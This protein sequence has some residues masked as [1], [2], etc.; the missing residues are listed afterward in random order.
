MPVVHLKSS[1]QRECGERAFLEFYKEPELPRSARM[2]TRSFTD[3]EYEQLCAEYNKQLQRLPFTGH[4]GPNVLCTEGD[5]QKLTLELVATYADHANTYKIMQQMLAKYCA[6]GRDVYVRAKPPGKVGF[7][8]IDLVPTG[9]VLITRGGGTYVVR[10]SLPEVKVKDALQGVQMPTG[11]AYMHT[12][13]STPGAVSTIQGKAPKKKQVLVSFGDE[14]EGQGVVEGAK[15]LLMVFQLATDEEYLPLLDSFSS[16]K[17]GLGF[18]YKLE[19]C[20]LI[21]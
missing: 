19:V 8:D 3:S 12:L 11:V 10:L 15:Y 6:Q 16:D 2:D 20:A 17:S 13:A 21:H 14:H 7:L 5:F 1:Q 9:T 18:V 4:N